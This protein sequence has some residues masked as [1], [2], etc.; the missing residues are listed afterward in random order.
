MFNRRTYTLGLSLAGA[1]LASGC[2]YDEGLTIKDLH[3]KVVLPAEAATRTF[4]HPDGSSETLTDPRLI[5]PVYLG[6]YSE[7]VDGVQAYP[8]PAIGPVFQP[9]VPGDTYPYGGTSLGDIRFPCMESL[10]CRV[11]SGRYVDFDGMVDWF[12]NVL[13]DPIVDA[14]GAEVTNGDYIAQ[15][16]FDLMDYTTESEIRL[17]ATKDKNEDGK[18]DKLDLDFVEQADGTFA[19][20]FTIYQQEYFQNDESGQGFSL[21]GWMDAPSDK[22][23]RFT[24][25][26]PKG[27]FQQQE[28]T[29]NFQGGRPYQD[30]LNRPSQYISSGDWVSGTPYVYTSVDDA[31]VTITLDYQVGLN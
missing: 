16:C 10:Q 24:T 5:G 28:Y 25:C 11:V 20:D 7:V 13:D 21:W 14:Y 4:F 31:D 15:T 17:T 23:Y 1:L 9:G 18:L 26:D 8:S 22:S 19:A 6:L 3:G 29:S 27:G 12:T 2:T 30:L